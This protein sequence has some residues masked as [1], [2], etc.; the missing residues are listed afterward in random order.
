[1]NE[2]SAT[3][4][5]PETIISVTL[6]PANHLVSVLRRYLHRHHYPTSPARMADIALPLLTFLTFLDTCSSSP[7]RLSPSLS[8]PFSSLSHIDRFFA[9]VGS[10]LSP[11]ECR[12]MRLG[13]GV[14]PHH[15]FSIYRVDIIPLRSTSDEPSLCLS[16]SSPSS[17]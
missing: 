14:L 10:L 6:E 16:S 8:L 12:E 3:G 13:L 7:T 1:M 11:D 15:L 2:H 9:P 5:N 17:A 4:A